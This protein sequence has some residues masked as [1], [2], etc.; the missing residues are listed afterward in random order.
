MAKGIQGMKVVNVTPPAAIV[1]DGSFAT[2]EVDT[3]GFDY[4]TYIISLGATDVAMAA[5]AVTEADVSATNHANITG[6]VFGTATTVDGTTSAL[7]ANTSGN[8]VHLVEIDLRGRKRYL[9]LTATAGNGSTGTFLAATC[10]LSSGEE[11]KDTATFRGAAQV[12][13]VG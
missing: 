10:I 5:L 12:L 8:T 7:P 6:A 9:D 1:D 13:R 2:T 11:Q 3:L 4:A